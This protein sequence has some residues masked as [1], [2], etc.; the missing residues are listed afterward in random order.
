MSCSQ[1]ENPNIQCFIVDWSYVAMES[2]LVREKTKISYMES[3]MAYARSSRASYQSALNRFD[4]FCTG[5]YNGRNADQIIS[6]L[7]LIPTEQRDDAYF[8][9]LQSY[10]NWLLKLLYLRRWYV[11]SEFLCIEQEC[12]S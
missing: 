1:S 5:A 2:F 10:V 4:E 12:L 3:L 8:G 11:Q 7:K 9:V 6:E